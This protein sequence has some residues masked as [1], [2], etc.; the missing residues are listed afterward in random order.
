MERTSN[1]RRLF[2]RVTRVV[3]MEM[4]VWGDVDEV[5]GCHIYHHQFIVYSSFYKFVPL[6]SFD[7][8]RGTAGCYAVCHVDICS[9]SFL[10]GLQPP[11]ISQHGTV[12]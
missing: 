8:S 11:D 5:I 4:H 7:H 6:N 3:G 9:C 1:C 2:D 12:S 10:H